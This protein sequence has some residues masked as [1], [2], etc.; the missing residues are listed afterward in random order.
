MALRLPPPSA[1]PT[2]RAPGPVRA[3][4]RAIAALA[5]LPWLATGCAPV[6]KEPS[7]SDTDPTGRDTAVDDTAPDGDGDTG[8]PDDTGGDTAADDGA[9]HVAPDGSDAASGAAGAPLRTLRA[10]VD[11]A[12][13]RIAAGPVTIALAPGVYPVTR[14]VTID[15]GAT[16]AEH[17]LTIRG[18]GAVLS[19]GAPVGAFTAREGSVFEAPLPVEAASAR[20]AFLWP[21]PSRGEPA[22]RR[23]VTPDLD[24]DD[25]TGLPTVEH[26]YGGD[27]HHIAVGDPF[28][29]EGRETWALPE[30]TATAAPSTRVE[31]VVPF[32]WTISRLPLAYYL[33]AGGLA[34]LVP[35]PV[36]G[37]LEYA[38]PYGPVHVDGGAQSWF[39]S[40]TW[41][42]AEGEYAFDAETGAVLVYAEDGPSAVE[43][44]VVPV[45]D[46][47]LAATGARNLR[48]EGLRFAHAADPVAAEGFVGW[49]GDWYADPESAD[50]GAATGRYLAAAVTVDGGAGVVFSECTFAELGGRAVR[51][52]GSTDVTIE[53]SSF[54]GIAGGGLAIDTTTGA[55]VRENTFRDVGYFYASDALTTQIGTAATVEYNTFEGIGGRAFYA[56]TTFFEVGETVT[57]AYNRIERPTQMISD[58]GA[59]NFGAAGHVVRR[60]HVSGVEQEQWDRGVDNR[61]KAFYLD[62]G[63]YQTSV[64]ENVVEDSAFFVQANCQVGN[65]VRGNFADADENEPLVSYIAC[66]YWSHPLLDA[67]VAAWSTPACNAALD[68]ETD[69]VFADNTNAA[70]YADV[71]ENA[72]AP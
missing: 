51:I 40:G 59:L 22:L 18:P 38:R 50:L 24:F 4:R 61:N 17:T 23:S 30:A 12:A 34:W 25:S 39:L 47:L 53:R 7:P 31:L 66:E 64:I 2:G 45:T 46:A 72:G 21:D 6:A 8:I 37:E 14:P 9:I 67:A 41:P 29:W 57:F 26:W 49:A 54:S 35:D 71:T 56:V 3:A 28:S 44:A 70:I 10:A 52:S 58:A 1:A 42:D 63:T 36:A 15:E 32:G 27:A 55:V 62:V 5:V 16:S 20:P 65:E 43:G 19:G 69:T 68:C 11:L 48:V 13:T 60:N 33:H